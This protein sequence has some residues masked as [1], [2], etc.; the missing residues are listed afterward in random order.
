MFLSLKNLLEIVLAIPMFSLY[1]L[2]EFYYYIWFETVIDNYIDGCLIKSAL[3]IET[4]LS[5]LKLI[6]DEIYK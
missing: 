1:L 4:D 3:S 6:G 2:K 5:F